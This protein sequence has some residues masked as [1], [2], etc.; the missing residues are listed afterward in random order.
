MFASLLR[1]TSPRRTARHTKQIITVEDLEGRQL[2]SLGAEFVIAPP[3]AGGAQVQ[4]A[5]ASSS[6]GSSVAVWESINNGGNQIAGQ[7]FNGKGGKVGP[8][9]TLAS[10]NGITEEQP[11]VAMDAHGNF[12]VS[13]TEAFPNGHTDILA[14]KFTSVG[15]PVGAV[16][17]VAVGTFPQTNSSV[18][19]DAK[20]DFVVSYTRETNNVHDDIF[21]KLYNTNG[22]LEAVVNPADS[23]LNGDHSSVAMTPDGR[24]DVAWLAEFSRVS[25]Q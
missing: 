25:N 19:M 9:L 1:R 10:A 17:P 6:N 23:F 22:Q 14:Q 11:S 24:F 2:M 15:A 21:A 3:I 12:V 18:A 8:V 4:G 5:N 20:G 7:I 13:W 16:V